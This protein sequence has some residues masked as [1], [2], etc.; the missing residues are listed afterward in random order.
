VNKFNREELDR[1]F[2]TYWRTGAVGEEWDAWA[3]LFTEDAEYVE[4][5]LGNLKGRE[6]I[7][8]WIKPIMA[9][10]GEL[11]TVYEWHSVDPE[12]GRVVVYMQNRRDHP[13]GDGTIDFPGITILDY[14]GNGKWKREEDFWALP[15]ATAATEEYEQ[16]RKQFDPDHRTKQ[17]RRHW[18]SGPAWTRGA[19][20][21]AARGAV[22]R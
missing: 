4:H 17:T 2:Q 6:A 7:R 19:E 9:Q 22:R 1:A 16:A 13:S 15:K 11:Y 20:S 14:A 3:D 18:G 10:Y 5:V 8:A 21:Y 12:S